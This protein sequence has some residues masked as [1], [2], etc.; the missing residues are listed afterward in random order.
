MLNFMYCLQP[1]R[2]NNSLKTRKKIT[3]DTLRTVFLNIH[4]MLRIKLLFHLKKL[5]AYKVAYILTQKA[6]TF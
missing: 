5:Y 1:S 6:N 2:G 4:Y 3:V